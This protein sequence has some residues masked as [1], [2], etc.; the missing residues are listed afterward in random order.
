MLKMAV[1]GVSSSQTRDMRP[2]LVGAKAP[3][4]EEDPLGRTMTVP[5][6]TRPTFLSRAL[7]GS[8]ER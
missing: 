5:E 1:N 3:K 7:R 4:D 6:G 2:P 8:C